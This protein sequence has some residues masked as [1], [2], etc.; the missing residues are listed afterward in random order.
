MGKFSDISNGSYNLSIGLE[1]FIDGSFNLI[2]GG[3]EDESGSGN[4]IGASGLSQGREY[5]TL[6]G[7]NNKLEAIII[8]LWVITIYFIGTGVLQKI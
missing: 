8:W 2:I 5:N 4:K 7:T 6:F 3:D 1:N